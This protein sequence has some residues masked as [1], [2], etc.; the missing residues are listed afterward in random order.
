MYREY[1]CDQVSM[2][3]VSLLYTGSATP[4]LQDTSIHLLHL[5]YKRFFMDDFVLSSRPPSTTV[6]ADDWASTRQQLFVGPGSRSQVH[7]S[8]TLAKLH[9][10]LTLPIF[11]GQY[12][13]HSTYL[14][15]SVAQWENV[16][17]VIS[18]SWVR[19]SPGQSCVTTLGKLFT[20]VCLCHQAV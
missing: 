1:P 12:F 9:P 5:L 4:A 18:R 19:F 14:E 13:I 7:L 8:L 6:D 3:N 15:S 2:L 10:D 16:G 11:S 17:L 20:P